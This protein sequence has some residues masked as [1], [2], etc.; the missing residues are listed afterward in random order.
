MV[1]QR[2]LSRQPQAESAASVPE[3]LAAK[4]P[5]PSS[6]VDYFRAAEENARLHSSITSQQE[7]SGCDSPAGMALQR[8]ADSSTDLH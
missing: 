1:M 6:C 7:F 5:L 2:K 3:S 4:A 8:T